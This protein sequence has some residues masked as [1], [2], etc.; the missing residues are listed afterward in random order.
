MRKYLAIPA[1][2]AAFVVSGSAQESSKPKPAAGP[3]PPALGEHRPN[4]PV[5]DQGKPG[6]VPRDVPQTLDKPAHDPGRDRAPAGATESKQKA[7]PDGKTKTA[8]SKTVPKSKG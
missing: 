6:P 1:V 7:S 8:P 2:L 3:T 4:N 5:P